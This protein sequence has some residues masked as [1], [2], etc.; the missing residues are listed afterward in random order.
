MVAASPTASVNCASSGT[1]GPI[2]LLEEQAVAERRQI[3]STNG[4]MQDGI[5]KV[6]PELPGVTAW[7]EALE[8]RHLSNLRVAEV[9][10]AL[11]ALSSAYVERR[12]KVVDGLTLDSA[13]K[14]AAF[15]LFY[16]PLHFL[17]VSLIVRALGARTAP[18]TILDIGCGTGVAG[19]AWAL[20][21]PGS[22]A[23]KPPTI[24]AIDRHPWAVDEARWTCR[25]L[26]LSATA[27]R[28]T[29][30][31]LP[32]G[33]ERSGIVAGW[34][35]NELSPERR[36]AVEDSVLSSAANGARVLIL[37]PLARGAAPW[38]DDTAAKAV[39]A[40]GRADEWK[41]PYALPPL[42]RLLDRSAGLR[43]QY[44]SARTI[45]INMHR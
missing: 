13:G 18:E 45:A 32:H 5:A 12:Q 39:A 29:L 3:A 33:N 7:L 27:R 26:G 31:H 36:L 20:A 37:E 14:R 4:R 1:V 43:H 30:E 40:G 17:T 41:F 42:Q 8:A 44:L 23:G 16:G 21:A 24:T 11:R 34:V 2:G 22:G 10:R 28:G 38:W 15:A 6:V 35:L 19:A 9:T 25:Q